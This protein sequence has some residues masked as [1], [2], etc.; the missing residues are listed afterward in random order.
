MR[1]PP[2]MVETG[3]HILFVC[4]MWALGIAPAKNRGRRQ[5]GSELAWCSSSEATTAGPA[6]VQGFYGRAPLG[7]EVLHD[8]PRFGGPHSRLRS[9]RLG[10]RLGGLCLLHEGDQGAELLP[11]RFL[12]VD[13]GG[14]R[15]LVLHQGAVQRPRWNSLS[16]ERSPVLHGGFIVTSLEEE[17]MYLLDASW[18][19]KPQE[20]ECAPT[21]CTQRSAAC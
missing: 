12:H 17:Y 8:G 7:G 14:S 16:L 10:P 13:A 20:N 21:S 2:N 18:C 11:Q 15:Q 4:A 19:L 6:P 3:S 9:A 1:Q 5:L